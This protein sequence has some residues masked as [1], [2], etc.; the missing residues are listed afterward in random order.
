MNLSD[1]LSPHFT[2][3]ELVHTSHR[4]IDNTPNEEIILS[5]TQLCVKF[6]EP[7]RNKFG[8]L[9]VNSGYRSPALNKAI[10]GSKTSAHMFG[11]AADIVSSTIKLQTIT[12]WLIEESNLDYDQII[13]ESSSTSNWLHIG[14]AKPGGISRKEVLIFNKGKYTKYDK[15]IDYGI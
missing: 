15:N 14:M 8:S 11:C 5:L 9:R 1:N 7:I 2:L 12:N 10:G 4:T 6:L 3:G 13:L